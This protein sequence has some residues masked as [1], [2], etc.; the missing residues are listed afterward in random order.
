MLGE[1]SQ[2]PGP[3]GLIQQ[4]HS[5]SSL[6][7]LTRFHLHCGPVYVTLTLGVSHLQ[8]KRVGSLNQVGKKE[9]RVVIRAI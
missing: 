8:V 9:D 3:A 2:D 6:N 1:G 4:F 5:G 7:E